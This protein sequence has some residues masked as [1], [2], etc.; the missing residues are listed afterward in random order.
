MKLITR[1]RALLGGASALASLRLLRPAHAAAYPS[2]AV[3]LVNPFA[4]GG[5]VDAI[6][7]LTAVRMSEVLGGQIFVEN[8]AGA[9]GTIGMDRVA[10]AAPDGQT[11]GI[12]NVASNAIAQ[13]LYSKL[14]YNG[15]TDFK[16]VGMFGTLPNV[17]V[18]KADFPARDVKELIAI[19]KAKPGR[20][21]F[22]SAGN[23]STPHLCGEMF[24]A[25]AGI[26]ALHV[27]YR[28][29]GPALQALLAGEVDFLFDNYT[30]SI[31]SVKAGKLR[32]LGITSPERASFAPTLPTLKEQGLPRFAAE[33]WH[34]IS[35]P[36]A[37]P[38]EVI[39]QLNA[40][41]V[42][43]TSDPA[44][45]AR[46]VELGVTPST[47]SPAQYT[48]FIAAEIRKW[49]EVIKVSGARVD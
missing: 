49:G 25:Q 43:A 11:L 24:K 12:S 19:A 5:S 41:L 47:F 45:A 9:G 48:E 8:I 21:N 40:A 15:L 28:G 29:G 22:S 20:L 33:T 23:G 46:L 34:G 44:V 26:F 39:S 14:P 32:V 36:A 7:R 42:K 31:A 2:Q 30:T 13:G 38:S 4:P 3:R 18:V 10:K 27:P 37:T 16:H 1:R 6:S 35:A 17:L